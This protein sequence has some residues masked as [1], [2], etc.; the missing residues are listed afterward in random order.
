M[1]CT[2]INNYM[3]VYLLLLFVVL[4]N[5]SLSYMPGTVFGGI[6][7]GFRFRLPDCPKDVAQACARYNIARII[8][9]LIDIIPLGIIIIIIISYIN[10]ILQCR[11]VCGGVVVRKRDFNV[12]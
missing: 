5:N 4:D 8:D 11:C 1:I 12:V 6:F 3:F 9:R 7:L 10:Y 2:F